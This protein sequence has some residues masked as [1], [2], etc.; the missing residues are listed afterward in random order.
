MRKIMIT[1]LYD[2]DGTILSYDD[3]VKPCLA[4]GKF[5]KLLKANQISKLV[6]VSSWTSL[7]SELPL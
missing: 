4:D 1:L 6:C 7:F 3:R 5:L 2:I